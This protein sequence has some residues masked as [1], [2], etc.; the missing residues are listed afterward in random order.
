MGG[1]KHT[2]IVPKKVSTPTLSTA[3]VDEAR[4]LLVETVYLVLSKTP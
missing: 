2:R 4:H 3:V 1:Q